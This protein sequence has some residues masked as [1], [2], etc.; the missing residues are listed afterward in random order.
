VISRQAG[1]RNVTKGGRLRNGR[2]RRLP[3]GATK[4][5]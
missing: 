3:A 4:W 2:L 1:L 5:Y